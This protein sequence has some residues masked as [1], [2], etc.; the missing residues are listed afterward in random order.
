MGGT[1]SIRRP[2]GRP[3]SFTSRSAGRRLSSD[4]VRGVPEATQTTANSAE[5]FP[6]SVAGSLAALAGRRI[7]LLNPPPE[8][9]REAVVG[10]IDYAVVDLDRLWPLRLMDGWTL[11][12]CL[13]YDLKGWC[14][15][16]ER[17]GRVL[18]LDTLDDP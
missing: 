16:L 9:S 4:P 18:A 1:S 14:W 8:Q 6:V 3:D 17:D 5:H 7:F 10:D 11:C 12:Q 13:H 15:L 2:S